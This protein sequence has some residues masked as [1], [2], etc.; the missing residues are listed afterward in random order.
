METDEKIKENTPKSINV[1][2]S[3]INSFVN[4][5][6]NIKKEDKIIQIL[7]EIR[8]FID[9]ITGKV[10]LNDQS[11]IYLFDLMKETDNMSMK[12]ILASIITICVSKNQIDLIYDINNEIF[13]QVYE[14]MIDFKNNSQNKISLEYLYYLL[15]LFIIYNDDQNYN[16][17]TYIPWD[18]VLF[19]YIR[20]IIEVYDDIF[21]RKAFKVLE[22][23]TT[24]YDIVSRDIEL[25]KYLIGFYH[26]VPK[27][28]SS[29]IAV[30]FS[31]YV[32]YG[33]L[34]RN[35]AYYDFFVSIFSCSGE[36]MLILLETMSKLTK[37]LEELMKIDFV[38]STIINYLD[39]TTVI[40]NEMIDKILKVF[41]AFIH[42]NVQQFIECFINSQHN[43]LQHLLNTFNY[44]SFDL[45]KQIISFICFYTKHDPETLVKSHLI[46]SVLD[47]LSSTPYFND[48]RL[49][50]NA[51]VSMSVLYKESIKSNCDINILLCFRELLPSEVVDSCDN[52]LLEERLNNSICCVL[53]NV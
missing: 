49:T 21:K 7:I 48:N 18:E 51:L 15:D 42:Q 5:L 10:L 2:E 26:D 52:M 23:V 31:N 28:F 45:K 36:T 37:E 27:E 12:S 33:F 47:N 11:Y 39:Q 24:K 25:E 4:N 3:C 9:E 35:S 34:L 17:I 32:E 44:C 29:N 46:N 38:C 19:G 30:I 50:S 41:K 43:I 40:N 8:N 20:E 16:H 1:Y 14:A 13:E 53:Q 22:I 6:K